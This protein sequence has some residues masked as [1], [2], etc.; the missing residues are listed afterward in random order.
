MRRESSTDGVR[1][2][3]SLGVVYCIIGVAGAAYAVAVSRPE[4]AALAAFRW[5]LLASCLA[6]LA[7]GIVLLVLSTLRTQSTGDGM[8]SW[9]RPAAIGGGVLMCLGLLGVLFSLVFHP[10]LWVGLAAIASMMLSLQ[11]LGLV[12]GM[13]RIHG[14]KRVS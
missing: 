10:A 3:R 6:F 7:V 9:L 13:Y 5:L 14:G 11:L 8:P 1:A 2:A 12:A 4:T